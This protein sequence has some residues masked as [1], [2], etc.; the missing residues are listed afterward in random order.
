MR[1]LKATGVACVLVGLTGCG[2]GSA[3]NPADEYSDGAMQVAEMPPPSVD[4]YAEERARRQAMTQT[5]NACIERVLR[6]DLNTASFGYDAG[7]A[8]AMRA[9]DMTGCPSDFQVAYVR[10]AQAWDKYIR[11]RTALRTLDTGE[12]FGGAALADFVGGALGF[13]AGA[14]ENHVDAVNALTKEQDVA[15]QE[16]SDTYEIVTTMARARGLSVPT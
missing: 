11:I 13:Q 15:N 9:I 5:E 16:I 3:P 10:H 14:I 6:E 1:N 7:R 8:P 4:P 2:P 12:N